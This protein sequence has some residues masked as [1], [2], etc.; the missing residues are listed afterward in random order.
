[1]IWTIPRTARTPHHCGSC[2]RWFGPGQRYNDSRIAPGHDVF[3]NDRWLRLAECSRCAE[4]YG[5][6][7]PAPA[8]PTP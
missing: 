2:D 8:E 4:R 6:P 1:M 7:I 5:R 3:G